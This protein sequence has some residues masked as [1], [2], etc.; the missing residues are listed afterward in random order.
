MINKKK[1]SKIIAVANQKGGVGKTTLS[2]AFCKQLQEETK[3][4]V[5]LV[6]FRS[7]KIEKAGLARGR[8]WC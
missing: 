5:K 7:N 6:Y 4:K 2:L 3:K 8:P 1:L